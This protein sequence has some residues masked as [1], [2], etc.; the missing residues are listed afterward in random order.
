MVAEQRVR[1]E[2]V[3]NWAALRV[4]GGVYIY[5]Q[6]VALAT[7]VLINKVLLSDIYK[8]CNDQ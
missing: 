7:I 8:E 6:E 3:G 2:L 4:D 5:S 1:T